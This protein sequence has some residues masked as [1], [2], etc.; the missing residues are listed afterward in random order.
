MLTKNSHMSYSDRLII[1][2]GIENGSTKQAI[3]TTLGKDKS[4][5]GKEKSN[6]IVSLHTN[7]ICLQSA[8]TTNAVNMNAIVLLIVS[9]MSLSNVLA[10]T[11]RQEL[12][13]DVETIAPAVMTNIDTLPSMH[14]TTTR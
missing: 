14:S 11:S 2:T 13:M 12:V 4:T 3:A 5:I 6:S 10:G 8:L 9:I 1:E 7:V